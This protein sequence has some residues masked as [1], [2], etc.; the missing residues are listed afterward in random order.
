LI[1]RKAVITAAGIGSRLLPVTKEMPKE[2]LPVFCRRQSKPLSLK[3]VVQVVFESL[4]DSGI[5]TFCMVVGRGKR[6]VEDYFTADRSF[7][8][9]LSKGRGSSLTEEL[10]HL[11]A[12]LAESSVVFMKQADP[13]GFGDA[14]LCSA[15]F[16]GSDPFV[17]HAGDDL[18]LSPRNDHVNRLQ[19][20]F[21][22]S[23]A[24]AMFFVEH[25]SHPE[26]YG[27]IRAERLGAD[28]YRVRELVEKPKH[29]P[30]HLGVV[31]I[32]AFSPD[33]IDYLKKV[34]PDRNGEFQLTDAVQMMVEDKK[35]V[36]A[37]GLRQTEKE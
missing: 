30:S 27:V 14:V 17:V 21:T 6:A 15:A 20:A 1:I 3:P 7:V 2:M 18:I 11:Y 26:K 12:R 9:F 4:F 10:S 37:I 25:T 28:L 13:L 5:R 23:R 35:N 24:D 19:N 8:A 31:A 22:S 36:F 33:V 34:K 32:Y 29:P 16:V